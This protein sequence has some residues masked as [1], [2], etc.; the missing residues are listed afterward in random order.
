MKSYFDRYGSVF[1]MCFGPKS[2]LVVSDPVI[3]RCAAARGAA[4]RGARGA[5]DANVVCYG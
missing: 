5:R 2:F 3:T 4:R 1:K